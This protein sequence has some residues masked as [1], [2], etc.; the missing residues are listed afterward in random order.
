MK[1]LFDFRAYQEFYP[2]GVSRYVYEL[3]LN[4]FKLNCS[5]NSILVDF[6]KRMPKFPAEINKKIKSYDVG[7][8]ESGEV[9]ETFD[10]F[11]NGSTTWLGLQKYNSLDVLYPEAVMKLCKQKTCILYD[12]VPLLY[13]NYL[14]NVRDQVNYFLQC[15]AMKY[16]DHIFTISKYVSSSGAR[17]LERPLDDFTCLYGGA[18]TEKFHTKN[19]ELEY[20][21]ST[22]TNN[23][24]NISGICVRKNFVGVTE[25]FCKAYNTG[26]LPR[27]ARLLLVCSSADFFVNDIKSETQKAGLK[28]GKHVVATGFISDSEMVNLLSTSRASIYPSLYEGLGLPILESYTAGTPCIASNV[29]S[30]KELVYPEASFNP[31]DTGEI[32]DKIIEIY[33]ND[34]LCKESLEYGRKLI[35]EINWENSARVMMKKLEDLY[36]A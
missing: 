25:A 6:N 17:Y 22:R 31:F 3:F 15:E 35:K 32:A 13:V 21:P 9:T 28:Y 19:S 23:L 33:N 2:R 10:F 16:M 8:F 14:P 24:V 7:Q 18:D 26:K 12:F 11:I 1:I 27:N 29:S 34:Q 20:D 4:A 5:E 30:M 36:N